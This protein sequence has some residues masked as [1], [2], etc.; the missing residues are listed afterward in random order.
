[1]LATLRDAADEI[2]VAVDS[3]ADPS[4]HADVAAVAD[5]LVVY[6]YAEPVERA[7]PWLFAQCRGDWALS[8]DDDEVPSLALLEAL[9]ELLAD[10]S[11]AHF[12]FPVRWLYPDTASYLD[13]WPWQ[14]HYAARLL[15]TDDRLIRFSNEMHR[16][17]LT[18]GP[19]RFLQVPLWHADALLKPLD[20]RLAKARRY[21]RERPGL[22][23]A[24]RAFNYAFYVPEL[25][26]E[27]VLAAVP[28]DE[29]HHIE[30]VL[31][32]TPRA[33]P[34][35]ATVE[36][37]TREEIDRF[38]PVTDH[39]AQAGFLELVD[40]PPSLVAGEERTL[41]V[42]VHNTGTATWPWGWDAVPEVR[43][44][45]RWLDAAG[46]ELPAL[47]I[48]AAL[49]AALPA[50]R[51]D[52]LPVHVR[53]PE[54]P[55]EYTVELGLLQ[56]HAGRFGEVVRCPVTVLPQRRVA[57]VGDDAAAAEVALVLGELPEVEIVRLRR[58]PSLGAAGYREAPDGRA[59]L[60]DDAPSSRLGFAAALLWRS[61]RLRIG[62]PPKRA[63]ELTRALEGA[64]LLVVAG[65]DGPE[66]RRERWALS[67]VERLAA[68]RGVR[69]ART[70]ERD[71]LLRLLSA[72]PW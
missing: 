8:I 56:E 10:D 57:V 23:I 51:D 35:R 15:R 25:R 26:R 64:E 70:R 29:R 62:R 14:P 63:A 4:A 67:T 5:R 24:G 36:R 55:G 47:E 27:P 6:P 46:R 28:A 68:A 18:A 40:R 43:V 49:A 42:R 3:R 31:Y 19:G 44:A 39:D 53:A 48:H 66:Q 17:I 59:Y 13:E 20:D 72:D 32:A 54:D 71:E 65:L 9:P 2:V 61:V 7:T 11:V 45:S 50:G 37:V 58:T 16:S 69:V 1:V 21:E 34:S 41:D 52:L 12:S 38:W 22:R 60:F 33:A 30:S